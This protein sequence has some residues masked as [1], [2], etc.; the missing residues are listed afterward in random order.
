MPSCKFRGHSDDL[1]AAFGAQGEVTFAPQND[2]G[3]D[4]AEAC[5]DTYSGWK[6]IDD[7]TGAAYQVVASYIMG[8]WVMTV[9]LPNLEDFEEQAAIHAEHGGTVNPECQFSADGYSNILLF[10]LPNPFTVSLME[11]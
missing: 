11:I 9:A 8:T 6:I 1:I 3:Y 2:D 7:V 4:C 10:R 5:G